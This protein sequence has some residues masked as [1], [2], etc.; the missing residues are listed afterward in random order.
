M[1][2]S[3]MPR[4][5]GMG[6]NPGDV[7]YRQVATT[8]KHLTAHVGYYFPN[9][10][11]AKCHLLQRLCMPKRSQIHRAVKK[12]MVSCDAGSNKPWKSNSNKSKAV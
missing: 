4:M 12:M 6:T 10:S 5:V 3:Q 2:K 8:Q 7:I 9:N 11:K 1:K